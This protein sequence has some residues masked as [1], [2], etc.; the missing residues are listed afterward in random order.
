MYSYDMM[1]PMHGANAETDDKWTQFLNEELLNPMALC[2]QDPAGFSTFPSKVQTSRCC[3]NY[4]CDKKK[5]LVEQYCYMDYI[6]KNNM[7]L[8]IGQTFFLLT[9]IFTFFMK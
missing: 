8:H 1:G 4:Y 5:V 6:Y 2:Y 3:F 9:L 7:M